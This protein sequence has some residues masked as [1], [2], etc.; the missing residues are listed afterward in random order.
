MRALGLI[1]LFLSVAISGAAHAANA[2]VTVGASG[3]LT[4]SP[5]NV[6]INAGETVTFTYGGGSMPH[7]VVSDGLFR[8]AKGC[9]GVSGGN[10][11]TTTSS[12]STVVTLS[13]P[14]TFSFYCEAH[15]TPT[16]GMHGTIKVNGAA[17]TPD[18]S[19]GADAASV[20]VTQGAST[21]VGITLTAQNGFSA[22][23]AYSVSG[24]PAGVSAQFSNDSATHATMTLAASA[25]ATTG[26]ASL[27][28]TATSGSLV[29]TAGASVD[30]VAAAGFSIV[31]GITG[32]W[33]NPAQSGQGFNIEIMA[34]NT[35][36]AF[37]YVFDA[38]GNDLWLTG[39]GNYSGDTT[40]LAMT[41]TT[42]GAFPPAFDPSKIVR[43]PWG[44]LSLQFSDCNHGSATWQPTDTAH[45]ASGTMPIQRLTSV[46]G[47]ACP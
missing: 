24:L 45:F 9:D 8:C 19:I 7:N 2:S 11:N 38:S 14:G 35:F 28:I 47:V 3:S 17:P 31:P 37:W 6:A 36:I 23:V 29:H 22:A 34:N 21:S 30:V 15:G 44:T 13:T 20:S 40:T 1:L 16:S 4:F 10:G 25:T 32:S 12:F 26:A 43:T 42:G 39:I 27:T 18:F 5:A 41:Q 33:Y 46:A